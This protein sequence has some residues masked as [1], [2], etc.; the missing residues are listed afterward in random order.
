MVP[1]G[2]RSLGPLIC[3]V[4][5]GRA[6]AVL[7]GTRSPGP[8]I[9]AVLPGRALWCEVM[10]PLAPHLSS[11]T[12]LSLWPA[13]CPPGRGWGCGL[14]GAAPPGHLHGF[15]GCSGCPA[16][17]SR[18]SPSCTGL[19]EIICRTDWT[20]LCLLTLCDSSVACTVSP[21]FEE[22]TLTFACFC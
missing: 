8:L 4:L 22:T 20:H 17:W 21:H 5:P 18:R 7:D 14:S 19:P 2:V 16:R 1:S 9:S 10:A 3:A 13:C 12:S 15:S 11:L 6:L